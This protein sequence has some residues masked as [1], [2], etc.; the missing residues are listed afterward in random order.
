MLL[1]HIQET[2]IRPAEIVAMIPRSRIMLSPEKFQLL[3]ERVRYLRHI[4]SADG[5][6]IGPEYRET[7]SEQ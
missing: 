6:N 3:P 4:V 2:P 5:M 1:D 7:D